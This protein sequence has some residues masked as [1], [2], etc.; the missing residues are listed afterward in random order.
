MKRR[1]YSKMTR[2]GQVTVPAEV[3]RQMDLHI[4][5]RLEF[6]V[7]DGQV[8]LAPPGSW[9]QRT[10]GIL[11]DRGTATYGPDDSDAWAEAAI[12][13]DEQTKREPLRE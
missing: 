5:D 6:V 10:Y 1:Y 13:R 4:G 3:R 9:A 11:R 8:R 2:K 12:E 7:E